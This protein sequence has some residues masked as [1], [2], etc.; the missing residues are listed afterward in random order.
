VGTNTTFWK[1]AKYGALNLMF[2]YSYLQR[3]PWFVTTGQPTDAH[4]HMGFVN[5]RYTLPGSAPA[6][7]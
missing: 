1:D 7:K 6:I 5:L 4:L 3:N 2:Q